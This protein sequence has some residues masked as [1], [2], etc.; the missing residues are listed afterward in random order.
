MDRDGTSR[1]YVVPRYRAGDGDAWFHFLHGNVPGHEIDFMYRPEVPQ[2]ALNQQ[3]FSHLARLMRYIEPHDSAGYAFTIGNLS[4]DDTQYEPGHGGVALIF[5]LRIRGATD[6][7]GRPDPPFSHGIAAIDRALDAPTLL[8]SAVALHR[9][10]LGGAASA[11]WYRSYVRS[12]AASP[13]ELERVFASY[14]A[15]FADL[16]RPEES[17]MSLTWTMHGSTPP[18]RIVFV[19]PDGAPFEVLARAASRIAAVLYRSDV[20]WSAISNGR[21][22]DLPNGTTVRFLPES[23]VGRSDTATVLRSINEI[24][25]EEDA[26]AR[27]LFGAVP[28]P[29]AQPAVGVGL[30]RQVT[31]GDAP[32][33]TQLEMPSTIQVEEPAPEAGEEE[34]PAQTTAPAGEQGD[35][36]GD[37]VTTEAPTTEAPGREHPPPDDEAPMLLGVTQ[38]TPEPPAVAPPE[39]PP[40]VK[41]PPEPAPPNESNPAFGRSRKKAAAVVGCFVAGLVAVLC[42]IPEPERKR[43]LP[44]PPPVPSQEAPAPPPTSSAP[45]PDNGT[46]IDQAKV[47]PAPPSKAAP[48]NGS[49]AGM[50]RPGKGKPGRDCDVYGRPCF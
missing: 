9:R 13:T 26:I 1:E 3:H 45:A 27:E 50:N 24:P 25:E 34:A 12:T 46:T 49:K 8:H 23:A 37:P 36:A 43:D 15:G 6:H 40:P 21:E 28:M 17:E 44:P 39:A 19:Y 32:V 14:V 38:M 11:E 42:F 16:P 5:G 47:T 31:G 2:G 18:A 30:E 4:R 7:A 33:L 22:A 48:A 20:R 41:E 10:V 35:A 29:R